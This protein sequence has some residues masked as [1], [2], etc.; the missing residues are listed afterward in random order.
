MMV[1]LGCTAA[2]GCYFARPGDVPTIDALL[3]DAVRAIETSRVR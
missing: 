3:A 1:E 2:Q